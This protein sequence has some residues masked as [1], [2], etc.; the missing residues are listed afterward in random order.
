VPNNFLSI[1][2]NSTANQYS[3]NSFVPQALLNQP[4]SAFAD[5]SFVQ[6]SVESQ[7]PANLPTFNNQTS[8]SL[9]RRRMGR[10]KIQITRIQ[11]ERNR[12]V[13]LSD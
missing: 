10:K 3:D 9:G 8:N 1:P 7:E 6:A 13:S 12:Q 2:S 11:D 5:Q 4:K